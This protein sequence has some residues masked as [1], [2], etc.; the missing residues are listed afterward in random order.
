MNEQQLG[1]DTWFGIEER[2]KEKLAD[3]FAQLPR[4]TLHFRKFSFVAVTVADSYSV[5]PKT[6]EFSWRKDCRRHLDV[7][8]QINGSFFFSPSIFHVFR[9]F[10]FRPVVSQNIPSL[11]LRPGYSPG[12]Q[13]NY[14]CHPI[15]FNRLAAPSSV[16]RRR[17]GELS[18]C[19]K[20]YFPSPRVLLYYSAK[21]HESRQECL[22]PTFHSTSAFQHDLKIEATHVHVQIHS[23]ERVL[24]QHEYFIAG[25]LVCIKPITENLFSIHK[26]RK[27]AGI[28]YQLTLLVLAS[29]AAALFHQKF[30]KV[31]PPRL[32]KVL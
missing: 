25:R 21:W 24:G 22:P 12:R 11:L 1:S 5:V 7:E 29:A 4:S 23:H 14:L 2:E 20:V 3:T 26:F 31:F 17:G 19:E 28:K 27:G 9:S 8:F 15:E 16:G 32:I 6:H 30:A 13:S 10:S 18:I